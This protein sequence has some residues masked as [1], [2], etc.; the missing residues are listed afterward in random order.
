MKGMK[1]LICLIAII[2]L[3][4][5]TNVKKLSYDDIINTLSVENK[6]YNTFNKGYKF[7]TPKGLRVEELWSNSAVIASENATYYLYID[8]ISYYNKKDLN[9]TKK[10]NTIYSTT[11]NYQDKKGYVEI[12]LW[13]N[14][15][16]LIEIMY[17]YAKIEVMVDEELIN[18]ALINSVNILKS[19]NY[20]DTIIESLLKE[21]RLNY[22]EEVFDMFEDAED[23]SNILDYEDGNYYPYEDT[24]EDK[25]TDYVGR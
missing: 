12:N 16:Y 7:Y 5:C 25:D 4:G 22:T 18:E 6:N 10:D 13:E 19:V 8:L 1:I 17:N 2:F 15:K 9:Y 20:N 11:I 3:S 24:E 21:D 14:N 23:N